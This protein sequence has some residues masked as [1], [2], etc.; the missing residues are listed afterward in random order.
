MMQH[1]FSAGGYEDEFPLDYRTLINLLIATLWQ[2]LDDGR[3][4]GLGGVLY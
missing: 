4:S 3:R 1:H 2:L